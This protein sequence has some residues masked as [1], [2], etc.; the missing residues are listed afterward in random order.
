MPMTSPGWSCPRGCFGFLLMAAL[1]WIFRN[2]APYGL[3]KNF[4]KLQI[5]SAAVMAFPHGTADAQK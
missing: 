3:N 5:L 2:S 1:M 4:R